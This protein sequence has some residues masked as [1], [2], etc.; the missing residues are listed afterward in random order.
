MN[1]RSPA[2]S[3]V[4]IPLQFLVGEYMHTDEDFLRVDSIMLPFAECG[5]WRPLLFHPETIANFI[6]P[7]FVG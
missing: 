2:L 6:S 1:P 3:L 5:P 7:W 4:A